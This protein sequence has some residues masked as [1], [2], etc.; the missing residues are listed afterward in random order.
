MIDPVDT[1]GLEAAVNN[2]EVY[3]FSSNI[4]LHFVFFFLIVFKES[5]GVYVLY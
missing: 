3:S 2:H 5:A 4:C 1:T